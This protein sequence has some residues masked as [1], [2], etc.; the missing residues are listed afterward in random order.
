MFHF[1]H[2]ETLREWFKQ[3]AT[4]RARLQNIPSL[5]ETDLRSA[6]IKAINN[7]EQS[8]KNNRPRAL[9]QIAT[10]IVLIIKMVFD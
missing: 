4:L 5:D 6:Q 1:H 3:S 10:G 9:I 2:P 7:L 8:F